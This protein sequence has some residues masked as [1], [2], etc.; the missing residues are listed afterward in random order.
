VEGQQQAPL[1]PNCPQVV[2]AAQFSGN[3][4][5]QFKC[6]LALAWLTQQVD[7]SPDAGF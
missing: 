7:H 1:L 5:G 4:V 2:A 6:A 3:L